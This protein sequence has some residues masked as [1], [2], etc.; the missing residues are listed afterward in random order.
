MNKL[1]QRIFDA[2]ASEF[3]QY[4]SEEQAQLAAKIALEIAEKAYRRGSADQ[5]MGMVSLTT[6]TDFFED[7]KKEIL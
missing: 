3:R 4:F 7:F 1:E 5:F 2:M 6:G